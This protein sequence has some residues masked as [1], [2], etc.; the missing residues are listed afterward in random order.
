MSARSGQL[1]LALICLF[2]LVAAAQGFEYAPNTGQYRITSTMKI[3]Q[4]A[5][6]QRQDFEQSSHQLLSVT[7]T[8]PV[9]DTLTMVALLDSITI[10]FPM[11]VTPPGFDSLAGTKVTSKLSP[12][13]VVYSA[14]G[15]DTS[16]SPVAAQL[17][18][19]MS[20]VFPRVPVKLAPGASWTDTLTL[21]GARMGM[22]VSR[23]LVSKYTVV[24]DTTVGADKSWKLARETSTALSGSGAP[25]GQPMTLEGTSTGKGVVVISQKNV[26]LGQQAEEQTD[27][28]IVLAANG[29]EV[30]IQQLANTK[31]EKVK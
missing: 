27:I 29:M 5:M 23:R 4:E 11:G 7:L 18:E 22:E 14:Q 9:K 30:A 13:G 16:K 19:E 25:N 6:G 17:T 12:A 8:R 31:V 20:R 15:P 28:K 26:Y 3:S 2:P 21:K 24:G 10:S 1:A